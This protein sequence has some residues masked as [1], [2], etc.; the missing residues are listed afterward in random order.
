MAAIYPLRIVTPEANVFEEEIESLIVPGTLGYLG[1]LAHH[2]PLL[3]GLS[4][5]KLTIRDA[6]GTTHLFQ[7]DGGILEVSEAGAIVLTDQIEKT[8]A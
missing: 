2:A 3:T 4:Q 7:I 6:Q 1:V 5:G 8:L